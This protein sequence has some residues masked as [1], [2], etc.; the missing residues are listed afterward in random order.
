MDP[1]AN[2][3]RHYCW[4]S[5]TSGSQKFDICGT[6]AILGWLSLGRRSDLY[7]GRI[8]LSRVDMDFRGP[9]RHDNVSCYGSPSALYE[10]RSPTWI[11]SEYDSFLT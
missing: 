3:Q 5:N 7:S 4:R 10:P 9:Q 1:H 2:L 6:N 11:K 8:R